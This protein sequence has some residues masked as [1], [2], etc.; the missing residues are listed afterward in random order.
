[1]LLLI[2]TISA[3]RHSMVIASKQ[4]LTLHEELIQKD[5]SLNILLEVLPSKNYKPEALFYEIT[6]P[7]VLIRKPFT[8]SKTEVKYSN[9]G[10]YKIK[11]MNTAGNECFFSINTYTDSYIPDE[12]QLHI[13]KIMQKLRADLS[14][15]YSENI[16]LKELKEINLR[17]LRKDRR[18]M[19]TLIILPII[20]IAVGAVCLRIQKGFFTPNKK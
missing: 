4:T 2:L 19:M 3:W 12:D 16:K 5:A 1:M 13:K 10:S 6:G 11:I 14:S 9:M 7:N 17:A 18:W 8:D 20:Y 15:I